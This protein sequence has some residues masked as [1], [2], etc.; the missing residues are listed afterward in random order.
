MKLQFIT[1]F[2]EA[3]LPGQLTQTK[4][5]LYVLDGT[6]DNIKLLVMRSGTKIQIFHLSPKIGENK[7][8]PRY[9][10]RKILKSWK[11]LLQ[12]ETYVFFKKKNK[13]DS[14]WRRNQKL[15]SKSV[16]VCR[17]MQFY[18]KKSSRNVVLALPNL[19]VGLFMPI[20]FYTF[21]YT[22]VNYIQYIPLAH[23]HWTLTGIH[24]RPT[25]HF[26]FL[27][28]VNWYTHSVRYW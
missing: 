13:C 20:Y 23:V 8:E 5:D 1:V 14:S 10:A 22:K 4:S 26:P 15:R 17:R 12:N 16:E 6:R 21:L 18:A 27:A 19:M 24:T 9:F 2:C 3:C 11:I 25:Q 28:P 7:T